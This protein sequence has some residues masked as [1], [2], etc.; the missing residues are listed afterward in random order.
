MAFSSLGWKSTCPQAAGQVSLPRPHLE[1][2]VR[3]WRTKREKASGKNDRGFGC[4]EYVGSESKS[5]GP[6][7]HSLL[8]SARAWRRSSGAV[9]NNPM[10][11]EAA[12]I[13]WVS[14]E[15]A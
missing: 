2:Q 5:R 13:S 6:I 11:V 8:F 1:T 15:A 3:F 9:E 12:A 10:R 7:R 14:G 4:C